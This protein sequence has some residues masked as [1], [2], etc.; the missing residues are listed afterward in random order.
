MNS[1]WKIFSQHGSIFTRNALHIFVARNEPAV[2]IF[3]CGFHH[4]EQISYLFLKSTVL[5]SPTTPTVRG[6]V[7]ERAELKVTTYRCGRYPS[8]A[9]FNRSA[10]VRKVLKRPIPAYVVSRS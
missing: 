1:S 10:H 4:E 8:H 3:F 9:A 6:P 5:G 2:N 7:D